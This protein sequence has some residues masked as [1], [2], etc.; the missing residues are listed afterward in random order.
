MGQRAAAAVLS[1][2]RSLGSGRWSKTVRCRTPGRKAGT[3]HPKPSTRQ[4][5]AT[6]AAP[7]ALEYGF[8]AALFRRIYART[9]V[10][11]HASVRVMERLGMKFERET[12][13]AA[14]PTPIYSLTR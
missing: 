9:V 8:D 1:E 5:L 6:E 12:H 4:G 11:N 7:A 2:F 3:Q 14:R 13:L 10:P